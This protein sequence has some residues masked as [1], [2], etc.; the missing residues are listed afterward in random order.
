M[1]GRWIILRNSSGKIL[2]KSFVPDQP[3]SCLLVRAQLTKMV[4]IM[5]SGDML[6]MDEGKEDS[7]DG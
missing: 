1:D 2:E 3:G 6:S 5:E 7:Q 4:D